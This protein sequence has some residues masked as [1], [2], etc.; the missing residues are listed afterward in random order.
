MMS[1][2]ARLTSRLVEHRTGTGTF[3]NENV[4]VILQG[5]SRYEV[6]RILSLVH[7]GKSFVGL[8]R[9]ALKVGAF[10]IAAYPDPDPDP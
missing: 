8:P 10:V 5:S 6:S 7:L 3:L 9:L 4:S 1:A 2:M